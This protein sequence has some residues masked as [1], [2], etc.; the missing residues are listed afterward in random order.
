MFKEIRDKRRPAKQQ[1]L[2][3]LSARRSNHCLIMLWN[4][5]FHLRC[6]RKDIDECSSNNPCKNGG[7]CTNTIGGFQCSCISGF[8][9]IYCDQGISF[10]LYLLFLFQSND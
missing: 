4:F 1:R 7:T 10:H 2:A 9:G 5:V 8:E 3:G 6:S